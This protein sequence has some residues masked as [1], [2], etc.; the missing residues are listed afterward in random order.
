[1]AEV[2]FSELTEATGYNDSD[3]L[4]IAQ[5]GTSKKLPFSTLNIRDHIHLSLPETS[6]ADTGNVILKRWTAGAG[7][8]L[9]VNRGGISNTAGNLPAGLEI[10]LHNNTD[11]TNTTLIDAVDEGGDPVTTVDIAG[12]DVQ[13]EVYNATSGSVTAIAEINCEVV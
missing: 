3:I 12:D 8:T 1:M 5:S 6:V 4:A 10:R 13:I 2:K 9:R 11:S 7:E